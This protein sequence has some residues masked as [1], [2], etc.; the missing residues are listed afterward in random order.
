MEYLEIKDLTFQYAGSNN[1][2]LDNLSL[3]ITQGE[4]I[5]ICGT[6]GSGKSTLLK[7]LKPQLAPNGKQTGTIYLNNESIDALPADFSTGKIGYVMQNPENQIVTESVWQELAFGLENLGTPPSEIK[8]RIAEMVNFLG[9]EELLEHQTSELS[10]GQMQLL[11]LTSVLLMKPDILILD[12]PTTQLDP[13]TSQK[14]IDLI[15]RL[16]REMGLTILL[17]E[18]S[19]ESVFA[20]ADQVIILDDGQVIF[21]GE[22]R[23]ISNGMKKNKNVD[24]FVYSLPSAVQIYLNSSVD[25]DCPLTV[26]EGKRFLARYFPFRSFLQKE[27]LTKKKMVKSIQLKNCWFRYEKKSRDILAGIDFEVY[28]GEIFSLVGGNGSGKT[29]LLKVIAGILDCYHGKLSLFEQSI[30]KNKGVVGYLPQ[31]SQML[32][33]KDSVIEEYKM[34]L[35]NQNVAEEDQKIRIKNVTTLLDLTKILTQHPLDLSGGE[36]QRAAL[37]KLFLTDS[38]I[39]LLDEPTKGIDNFEKKQLIK[40][41][42]ELS[43]QGKT[44]LVVTHDLDFAAELS[45]RCGLLFQNKLVTTAEP[46]AFFSHHT[47]YTTAASRISRDNFEGL[48]TTE[49]VIKACRLVKGASDEP[50]RD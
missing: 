21:A 5:L 47:F 9:I 23:S 12:E 44:I 11:N 24:R 8:S 20:L 3:S 50:R 16:N 18:H 36:C 42:K 17:V 40:L 39:L 15:V 28:T 33:L 31:E 6:S 29:T 2:V 26:V 13:I 48:V 25:D 41:L 38:K 4:F 14:F 7:L 1:L 27:T 43:K 49:Q 35:Q 32:F 30:K 22:P 45:D 46:T 19:L 37:G 10:G 34:Y